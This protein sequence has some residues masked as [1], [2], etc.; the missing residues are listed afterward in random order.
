[1][2]S[3]CSRSTELEWQDDDGYRWAEVD[4]GWFGETGFE[5][6]S[7]SETNILFENQVT[8]EEIV[9]NRHY[10]NGSG[11]T[12]GDVDG[13]GLV[14]L[15]F[16]ALNGPNRLYKNLGN[17]E[18]R[19]ITEETGT[20]HE[21]YYS[22]GVLF[23][24]VDGDEDLD[25]FVGSFHKGVTLYINNGEGQFSAARQN[26][27]DETA[28]K[29]NTTLAMA[30]IDSDGD[31]DLYITNYKETT[32]KDLYSSEELEW[33]NILNEPFNEQN[34]TGPFTLVPPFDD[35]YTIYMT[36]DN[37]L[38]GIAESGEED[39][40]YL[41]EGGTFRKVEN[42]ETVFLD[43]NGEPL[44]L[45]KEW[46][47]T[48]KFQDLNN[49]GFPDLYVCNDYFSKD[50]IWMNRGDGTFRAL[51][52]EAIRNMS[53]ASMGVDFS[54]INHD[55]HLDI[56]VT[57][58]LSPLHER[59]QQQ[60]GADDPTYRRY[61]L[62]DHQPQ[63]NRN[64]L[65]LKRE[66]NTYAE[67]AY[68]SNVQ[69]TEWSWATRFMDINL[70]GYEDLIINT[71]YT[72][73]LLDI[74][75]QVQMIRGGQNISENFGEF[76]KNAPSL[77]LSNKFL[78]NNRDLTFS[79]ESTE[80]GFE[81]ADVSHGLA[82]ADLDNDGDLDFV[83]NRLYKP[84]TVFE[85]KTNAGRILVKL[86]SD[87][88]NVYGI[89]AK[90]KLESNEGIQEKQLASGGDYLSGATPLA[91]FAANDETSNYSIKVIWP[92]GFISHI[93]NVKS[94]RVYEVQKESAESTQKN[95]DTP[96]TDPQSVF[97]DISNRLDH[98][99]HEDPFNDEELQPLI[100]GLMS[101]LGPGLA[102]IDIDIDGDDD[103]IIGSGK[104][105][106][107]SIF[108]NRT[109]GTFLP[110]QKEFITEL[111]P[112]DQ[113]TILGW[114]TEAGLQ[115]L[116]GSANYEQGNPQAPAVY[117]YQVNDL[118]PKRVDELTN[119]STSGAMA[120]ADYNGDGEVDLFL[121]GRF[122]PAHY[123]REATSRLFISNNGSFEPDRNNWEILEQVGMVTGAVFSDYDSDGDP[124]LLLSRE[125]DSIILLENENGT[126]R[127]VSDD[128]GLSSFKGWWSGI[129]TGDFN[130]DGRPDIVAANRGLN[131]PYQLTNNQPIRIYYEDFN[132]DRR[133]DIIETYANEEGNYVPRKRLFDFRSVP[134]ITN[135]ARSYEQFA[136]SNMQDILGSRL[137]GINFKEINTLQ[138]LMFINTK[139]GFIPRELPKEAQLSAGFHVGVADFNNDGNEDLFMSQNYFDVPRQIPRYDSGRGLLLEGDGSG[140]L[141]PISG[142]ESGIKIYGEQRGAAFSDFNQD[143]KIDLAISQNSAQTKL[144]LNRTEKNGY[145]ISLSGPSDNMNGIGSAIRLVYS[146]GEKGPLREIQS[147][148]GYWSQDSFTQVMGVKD[149]K[150]VSGVEVFW[151]DGNKQTVNVSDEPDEVL[152]KYPY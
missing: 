84:A 16:A 152:I 18:F 55:G 63:Y 110:L 138:H 44:G 129:T 30:D 12:A 127:N 90:I 81:E 125:W 10:L 9:K 1:M 137:S 65:Y 29:G 111:A 26:Q 123:P 107:T 120:A 146:D 5:A 117:Q 4:P 22:T 140:N 21:G 124:D 105:G 83:N 86:K 80:W 119:Y 128:V 52:S 13:D 132:S 72:Y 150:K 45:D 141:Q 50:R 114:N 106:S 74:D 115:L 96:G 39:E 40:L 113:T 43:E 116:I 147:G 92:D 6:L 97:V 75:T 112:G 71:G 3:G 36:D 109:D 151:F 47:L 27:F 149:G 136:G 144:Y 24:D 66:D 2:I 78:K 93:E 134:L 64:S 35:H 32:V 53:F 88:P 101:R 42:T 60:V 31:L 69:A 34:Q 46:G 100:P 133:V 70:D 126:F 148:S 76:I 67:I 28:G 62:M 118:Q 131:S 14:D 19:D 37:R 104:G 102:W 142:S 25:L 48:A 89:G 122:V 73:D 23:A 11:V 61:Y 57:E 145:S 49:D 135:N 108:E 77:E 91:M 51:S 79:D 17:M 58:M 98:I 68:Y 94:N 59:R 130:N 103:L 54:D 20:A 41:N 8:D 139:E 33:N 56:F 85:N 7:P 143:G 38:A 15:Y 95:E 99:H 87:S 82:M 121:G